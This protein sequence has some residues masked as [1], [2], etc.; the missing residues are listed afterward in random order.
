MICN[1]RSLLVSS[2]AWDNSELFT[3]IAPYNKDV[4]DDNMIMFAF[5]TGNNEIITWL[6]IHINGDRLDRVW[7]DYLGLA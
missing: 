1:K 2:I 6:R 5:K 4:I 3:S 7:A